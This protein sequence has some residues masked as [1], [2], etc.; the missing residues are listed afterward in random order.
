[1]TLELQESSQAQHL[2]KESLVLI[3]HLV[4]TVDVRATAFACCRNSSIRSGAAINCSS[5]SPDHA[6]LDE[7]KCHNLVQSR[8]SP[9]CRDTELHFR[10][11]GFNQ[12]GMNPS[13]LAGKHKYPSI[14]LQTP[15]AIAVDGA[16]ENDTLISKGLEFPNIIRLIGIAAY[17]HQGPVRSQA[18]ISADD[19][20]WIIFRFEPCDV[21]DVAPA[22]Q[23]EAAKMVAGAG[24]LGAISQ[25]YRISCRTAA[26][27]SPELPERRSR[28][29]VGVKAERISQKWRNHCPRKFHLRRFRSNPSTFRAV[30]FPTSRGIQA[31]GLLATLQ[32]STTSASLKSTCRTDMKRVK[33][34]IEMLARKVGKITRRMR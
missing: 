2:C 10:R 12:C 30:G 15:I 14:L 27:S 31:N 32:M 13:N 17:N 1:M 23:S 33:Q 11:H 25:S 8:D 18:S 16:G 22:G 34:G 3:N 9:G 21:E 28:F 19:E 5:L 4:P 7:M 20:F 24:W 26:N 29:C 6:P